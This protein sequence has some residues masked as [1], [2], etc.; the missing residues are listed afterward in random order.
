MGVLAGLSVLVGIILGGA[1]K[2]CISTELVDSVDLR[3]LE[4]VGAM[5]RVCVSVVVISGG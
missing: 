4:R 1:G 2:L 3:F 5:L